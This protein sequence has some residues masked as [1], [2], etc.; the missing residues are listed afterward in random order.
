VSRNDG[1]PYF[2]GIIP[3]SFSISVMFIRKPPGI[4][5]SPGR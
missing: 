3:F 4:T 1:E 2:A 5:M